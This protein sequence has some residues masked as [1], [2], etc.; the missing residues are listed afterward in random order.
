M[1]LPAPPLH[2]PCLGCETLEVCACAPKPFRSL[3]A[4]TYSFCHPSVQRAKLAAVKTDL[5]NPG[6]ASL[7]RY[8]MDNVAGKFSEEHSQNTSTLCAGLCNNNNN[9]NNIS[10]FVKR[11]KVVTSEALAA[12]GCVCYS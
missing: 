5:F 6:L 10:V 9:N 11:N 12:V 8:D 2:A 1:A 3:Y 7:K 4:P